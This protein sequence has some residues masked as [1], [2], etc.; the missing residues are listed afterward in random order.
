MKEQ[1]FLI[2]WNNVLFPEDTKLS[3]SAVTRKHPVLLVTQGMPKPQSF[4]AQSA[5]KQPCMG[6][7]WQNKKSCDVVVCLCCNTT[8]SCVIGNTDV[9]AT[10]QKHSWWPS[11]QKDVDKSTFYNSSDHTATVSHSSW[12]H[13]ALFWCNMTTGCLLWSDDTKTGQARFNGCRVSLDC[14]V[15]L[16]RVSQLTSTLKSWTNP[17]FLHFAPPPLKELPLDHQQRVFLEK[18]YKDLWSFV[19][20]VPLLTSEKYQKERQI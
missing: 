17:C 5:N 3:R 11:R 1:T 10:D 13:L 20:H 6:E 15:I 7:V 14:S 19:S 2:R 4:I 12:K 16:F 18:V 8:G 9:H